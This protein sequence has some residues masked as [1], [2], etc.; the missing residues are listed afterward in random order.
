[1]F[2]VLLHPLICVETS[3]RLLL[4]VCDGLV[5][6]VGVLYRPQVLTDLLHLLSG[7]S[8]GEGGGRVCESK[9]GLSLEGRGKGEEMV[10]FD[11]Q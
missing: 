9:E 7:A 5:Q 8:E 3:T 10:K 4:V 11:E 1:M 6:V 2:K